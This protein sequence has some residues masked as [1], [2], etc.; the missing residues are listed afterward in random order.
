M[1]PALD[2]MIADMESAPAL[3]RP[4]HYWEVLLPRILETVKRLG[5]DVKSYP[6]F[7]STYCSSRYKDHP[8][9]WKAVMSILDKLPVNAGP[10]LSRRIRDELFNFHMAQ[11]HY[12]AFAAADLR[13]YPPH[14]HEVRESDLGGATDKPGYW[15]VFNNIPYSRVYLKYLRCLAMLKK[16][17]HA[18]SGSI[19]NVI[20]LGAGFSPLGEIILKAGGGDYFY[21]D[22]DLPPMAALATHYLREVFGHDA[23]LDY[24][25][26]RT[27][28]VIDVEKVRATHRAMVLCPWQLERLRGEFELFCN[29]T[30][31]QEMEPDVVQNYASVLS[32]LL[33]RYAL[34]MNRRHGQPRAAQKGQRGV[35]EPVSMDFILGCFK[36]FDI[37]D[38]NQD[39]FGLYEQE[40]AVLARP[41]TV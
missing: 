6:H 26:T 10:A 15:H 1:I 37:L 28:D 16:N 7:T 27:M 32:P 5:G 2:L 13:S 25:A 22:V 8:G 9:L 35:L 39:V 17:V 29:F 20:E 24:A 19:R 36:G 31:F 11:S 23:V 33:T 3:Y 38:R 12:T 41:G 40:A 21:V 14:L 30:S 34:I 4:T 18:G